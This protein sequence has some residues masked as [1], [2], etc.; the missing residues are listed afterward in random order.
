MEIDKEFFTT[1]FFT[2]LN[3]LILYFILKKLLFKP[4]G[5]YMETRSQ[6]ISEAL[7]MAEEAR[8]KVE[9]MEAEHQ[10]RLK[11]IKEEGI[12]L[13]NTYQVKA[14]S[15]YDEIIAQAK[16]DSEVIIQKTRNELQVEKEQLIAGLKTE[17][18]DLVL[19]A[20]EKILN[21]NL[22]S[23]TNKELV[24]EFINEKK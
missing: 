18:S 9:N 6:K 15:E 21:K 13:I 19:A 20:S 7:K 12:A 1:V 8:A 5:K 3:M 11:E 10:A 22:D 4:V 2:V 23:K 24:E 14:Q 16:K 17:I